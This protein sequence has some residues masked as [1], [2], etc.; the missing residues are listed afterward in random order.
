MYEQQ[1]IVG[2]PWEDH[3]ANGGDEIDRAGSAYIFHNPE[4]LGG[5]SNTT[6]DNFTVYPVPARNSITIESVNTISRIEIINQL[7]MTL[8]I[9]NIAGFKEQTL[10]ISSLAEGVYFINAYHI[11]GKKASQKIIKIN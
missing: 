1:L 3:D 5:V 10:D 9:K 2:A 6:L 11:D 7:G 8:K 4:I